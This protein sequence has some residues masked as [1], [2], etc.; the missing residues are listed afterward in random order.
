MLSIYVHL[1]SVACPTITIKPNVALRVQV[2]TKPVVVPPPPGPDVSL[3]AM[4]HYDHDYCR[5]GSEKVD[6]KEIT[7]YLKKEGLRFFSL[8]NVS[9]FRH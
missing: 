7:T 8:K 3:S 1:L 6:S 9:L 4:R 5:G 2:P